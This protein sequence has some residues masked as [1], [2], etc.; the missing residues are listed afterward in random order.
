LVAC[1]GKDGYVGKDGIGF[2][3]TGVYSP[4]AQYPPVSAFNEYYVVQYYGSTWVW[5]APITGL[6]IAPP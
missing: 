2:K 3:Y 4:E 5:D 6:N 1:K